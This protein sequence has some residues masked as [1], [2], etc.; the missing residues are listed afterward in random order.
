MAEW[1]E[2]IEREQIATSF[3]TIV[4]VDFLGH[5]AH[6]QNCAL[7]IWQ[8]VVTDHRRSAAEER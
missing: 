1:F 7:M 8:V 6:T 5:E 2:D 4:T 3:D